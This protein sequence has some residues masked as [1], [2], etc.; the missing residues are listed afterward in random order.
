MALL[1]VPTVDTNQ[2]FVSSNHIGRVY[3]TLCNRMTKSRSQ[4]LSKYSRL[5]VDFG[6]VGA[7]VEHDADLSSGFNM[8]S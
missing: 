6:F 1:Y 2:Y 3:A 4:K 8:K 7:S 5:T